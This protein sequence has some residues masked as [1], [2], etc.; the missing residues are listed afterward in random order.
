MTGVNGFKLSSL[1]EEIVSTNIA[2]RLSLGINKY[3]LGYI[4]EVR[5]KYGISIGNKRYSNGD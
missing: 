3:I 4:F 5:A 2:P 1:P